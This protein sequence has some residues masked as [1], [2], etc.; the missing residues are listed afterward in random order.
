M[1]RIDNRLKV[2]VL[3]DRDYLRNSIPLITMTTSSPLQNRSLST[4]SL[5]DEEDREDAYAEDQL[6]QLVSLRAVLLHHRP[7]LDEA[8][9]PQDQEDGSDDEIDQE[10]CQD[11]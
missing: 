9:E 6:L 8:E 5:D 10:R 3:K 4:Q 1:T 7:D 2:V 11:I